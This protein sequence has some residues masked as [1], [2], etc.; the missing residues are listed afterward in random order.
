MQRLLRCTRLALE[1]LEL[2]KHINCESREVVQNVVHVHKPDEE[3]KMLLTDCEAELRKLGLTQID[4]DSCEVND[5]WKRQ[6]SSL[7]V[8]YES[9]FSHDKL[10]CGEVKNIVHRIRLK[11]EKLF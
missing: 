4:I 9:I 8:P 5:F 6:L 2:I 10:D 11:D 7:I 3:D 1:E